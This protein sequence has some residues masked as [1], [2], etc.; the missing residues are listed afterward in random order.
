M[1][2][3]MFKIRWQCADERKVTLDSCLD[4]KCR[5][6]AKPSRCRMFFRTFLTKKSRIKPQDC[7]TLVKSKRRR[8]IHNPKI[9]RKKSYRR[10][11]IPKRKRTTK[12]KQAGAWRAIMTRKKRKW[13]GKNRRR[14]S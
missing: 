9:Q 10:K 1:I 11:D 2:S 6:A 13:K 8:P 7:Q 4:E 12:N 14:K 5:T 3:I